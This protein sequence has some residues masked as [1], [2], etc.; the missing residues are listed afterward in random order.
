[1][2]QNSQVRQDSQPLL[3]ICIPTYNRR[4]LIVRLLKAILRNRGSFE[5]RVHNDGSSD[6]TAEALSRLED[7]RLHVTSSANHGRA[8]ALA[9]VVA[10]ASGEFTMF[11]DDDDELWPGGL[12]QVL[13]DCARSLP[14]G[15]AGYVYHL[16][17]DAGMRLGDDFPTVKS[18]FLELRNDFKV[19]G[20]K[21]EVVLTNL[22]KPS[23]MDART[24]GRRVP[25]SLY[26]T[27]IAL[28]YDVICRNVE[29]GRK[30]Y[31][32]GGMSDRIRGLKRSNP[33][34]LVALYRIHAS[35]FRH[36][37]FR[38]LL[39][40]SRITLAFTYHYARMVSSRAAARR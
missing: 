29:I 17:D 40:A 23:V 21:K 16:S 38:S 4:E 27:T 34:P 26:W 13:E 2:S 36:G 9:E 7:T 8:A 3:S 5:I 10:G 19:R 37:R 11:F 18:N 22:L 39:A 14:A 12:A 15:V 32:K 1:M 20:D 28:K 25:T 24:L 35:G 31:E 33:A 30:H 6:G